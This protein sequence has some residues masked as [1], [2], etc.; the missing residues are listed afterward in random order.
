MVSLPIASPLRGKGEL[1]SEETLASLDELQDCTCCPRD[2]H[3]ERDTD[4]LGYCRSGIGFNIASI[5]THYGEEPVVSGTQGICNVFFAHCNMQCVFCQNHQ[6]SR[7]DQHASAYL[8]DLPTVVG[9][10]E[11][12]LDSGRKIVGFVSP[13]HCIP[14]MKAVIGMLENRG[15]TP[16]YV[17][18][19][20]A[21]DRKETVETLEGVID[22]Y[23]PD[24]KYG[25]RQLA[26]SYADTPDYPEVAMRA[27]KE[28]FRQKGS[29]IQLSN[30]GIIES[31]LI[32]RH[33]ILPGQVEN[34]KQCLRLIA[35]E[36]STSVYI[37]LMAQYCPTLEVA[38]HPELR[39]CLHQ[40]EY[41]E[42]IEEFYKLGFYRGWTQ[43]LESQGCY[44]PDFTR[45][46]VFETR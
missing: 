6:I 31:G 46:G 4:R 35:D 43:E 33:L 27:I 7:N 37:S 11:H 23:L 2:C 36:L 26:A 32:I 8:T 44:Q 21:Y 40:E 34:S 9:Q 13:S 25:D 12:I 20:N 16:I 17:M 24:F 14:Q 45:P 41:D 39:R 15:R 5:C 19:T 28:M 3:A 38:E 18:N 30:D 22:V 42:V 10:I 29:N 1:I